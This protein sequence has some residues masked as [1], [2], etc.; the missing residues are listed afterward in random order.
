M[1]HQDKELEE[2]VIQLKKLAKPNLKVH[3]I[4]D[5]LKLKAVSPKH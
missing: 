5:Y 2:L 1:Y 3:K 4:I